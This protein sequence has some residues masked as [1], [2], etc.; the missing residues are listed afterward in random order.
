MKQAGWT[1]TAS[2]SGTG[3]SYSA[4]GDV[5]D[6]AGGNPYQYTLGVA[7]GKLGSGV[8]TEPWIAAP[9]AWIVLRSPGGASDGEVLFQRDTGAADSSDD[10]WICAWAP[11]GDFNL[12]GCA[13]NIAPN[14]TVSGSLQ[15][16]R[17]TIN[18]VG[19]SICQVGGLANV[20]TVAADDTASSAGS[21]GVFM[22]EVVSPQTT[23]SAFFIDD[24]SQ[25]KSDL[26]TPHPKAIFFG[27]ALTEMGL[28]TEAGTSDYPGTFVDLGGGGESWRGAPY[29]AYRSSGG[30]LIPGSGGSPV[31]GQPDAPILVGNRT[32]GGV[33]FVS[34]WLQWAATAQ[35]HPNQD[36]GLTGVFID[37]VFIQDLGDGLTTF[38]GAP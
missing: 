21:Y 35:A 24:G 28:Y 37:D 27:P 36:T 29:C 4:V 9:S 7:S 2:G 18:G 6:P 31:A 22:L 5:F 32:H 23:K 12:A 16:I 14:A 8:G 13:A 3:G 34:R 26:I 1:V 17:G 11:N 20:I 10:E 33:F 25:V 19:S 15:V 38:T 30:S